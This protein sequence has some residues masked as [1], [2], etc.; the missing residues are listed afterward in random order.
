MR[1]SS[2]RIELRETI[3]SE[4]VPHVGNYALFGMFK[5]EFS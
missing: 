5:P 3:K 4:G 1:N 2:D